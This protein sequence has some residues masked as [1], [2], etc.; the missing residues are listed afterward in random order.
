VSDKIK[1]RL[2]F[3]DGHTEDIIT[4][5]SFWTG[6]VKVETKHGVYTYVNF[7]KFDIE[8]PIDTFHFQL[9]YREHI[10]EFTDN[11]TIKHIMRPAPIERVE[12]FTPKR[13]PICWLPNLKSIMAV[14]KVTLAELSKKTRIDKDKLEKYM[15]GDLKPQQRTVNK[16]AAV[17]EV[18]PESLSD[19][20]YIGKEM[21][22][23]DIAKN[24]RKKLQEDIK[25]AIRASFEDYLLKH[26]LND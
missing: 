16:I 6:H 1:G 11:G 23:L 20:T 14:K 13:K 21:L 19:N 2:Y 26:M 5:T 15:N 8:E 18:P 22:L 25:S 10:Q 24:N 7:P 4:V 9:L 17:L 3:L 12:I